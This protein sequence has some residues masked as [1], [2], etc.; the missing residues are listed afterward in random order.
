[1]HTELAPSPVAR[2]VQRSN[3]A[4]QYTRDRMF[5]GGM[6]VAMGLT[7]FAGF[8][9]SYYLRLFSGGPSATISGGPFTRLVHL[10]GALFTAWVVLFIIQ[11][12]LVAG[13]RVNVH[14]RLGIVGAVLAALMIVVGTFTAIATASRGSAPP[15]VDPLVFLV[16][17]LFDMILFTT[18]ITL[19][20]VKRRD[21]EAH[22][23]LMLLAYVSIIVA[24]VARM[25]GV[26]TLGPLAFFGLAFLFILMGG[27]YD[28]LSRRRIH[29]VYI[30]GGALFAISVP[31]RL[32]ISGTSAWRA[33]A[34]FLIS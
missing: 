12:A 27:V 2:S 5:Y 3:A 13:R 33:F 8:S 10:H 18:F 24:A 25:P 11:T 32:M 23:R 29:P 15:G 21:R 6:A 30:W 31:V 4:N 28:F 16:V 14:R 26:L 22:K 20:L 7:V 9:S 1:M 34:K 17:P 19:A